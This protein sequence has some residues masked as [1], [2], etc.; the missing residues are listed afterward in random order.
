MCLS[1]DARPHYCTD[2][3]VTWVSGRDCLLVV[4][5]GFAIGAR[6]SL[7]SPQD[8]NFG[9]LNRHFQAKLVKSKNM[10]V[11]ETAASIPTKFCTVIKTTKCPSCVVQIRASQIQDGRKPP[12][13]KNGK[14]GISLRK[15]DRSPRN[16]A[17]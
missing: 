4:L 13:W 14:I 3:D 17:R 8:P 9:S 12:Y 5:G 1:A 15:F 10:H 6:I 16:L 11:I 7:L 2:P